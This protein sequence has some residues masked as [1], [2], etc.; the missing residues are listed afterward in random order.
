MRVLRGV[1]YPKHSIGFSI[2]VHYYPEVTAYMLSLYFWK[3]GY[4]IRVSTK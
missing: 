3:W 4:Y 2:G 1:L